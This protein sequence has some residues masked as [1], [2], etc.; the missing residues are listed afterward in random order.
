MTIIKTLRDF[1]ANAAADDEGH[2]ERRISLS[3][4]EVRQILGIIDSPV[5]A[6]AMVDVAAAINEFADEHGDQAA[7]RAVAKAMR[8]G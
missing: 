7:A 2:G 6:Q 5:T 8:N 3:E 1:I 4:T